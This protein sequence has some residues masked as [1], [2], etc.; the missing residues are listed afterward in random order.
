[1]NNE[2]ISEN[3]HNRVSD[4]LEQCREKH[5]RLV[6]RFEEELM[7]LESRGE[8]L[9]RQLCEMAVA[10]DIHGMRDACDQLE[11]IAN[12]QVEIASLLVGDI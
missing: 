4:E 3:E 10:R 5:R 11:L 2:T 7:L 8:D 6:D 12:L 9:M 1:M